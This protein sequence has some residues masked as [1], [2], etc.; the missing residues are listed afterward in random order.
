LESGS[1]SKQ[2][3]FY[4]G[5]KRNYSVDF[6]TASPVTFS[7]RF[8]LLLNTYYIIQLTL[9]EA[10]LLPNYAYHRNAT[11]PVSNASMFTTPTANRNLTEDPLKRNM[12]SMTAN[13]ISACCEGM[14]F[15]PGVA[16]AAAA[17]HTPVNVCNFAWMSV[18][19]LALAALLLADVML[20]VLQLR[21]TLAPDMLRYVASMIHSNPHVPMPPGG[22]TLDGIERTKLLRYVRVRISDVRGDGRVGEAAFVTCDCVETRGLERCRLYT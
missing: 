9:C 21:C 8:S 4:A 2:L 13:L 12:G 16:T 7:R 11:L 19:L 20:L 5:L 22:T 10:T 6:S 1:Y 3:L 15:I 18:L 17:V 14:P